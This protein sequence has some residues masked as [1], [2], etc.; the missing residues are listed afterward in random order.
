MRMRSDF[1]QS[2]NAKRKSGAG[3]SLGLDASVAYFCQDFIGWT[4]PIHWN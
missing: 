1:A 4:H 2:Y 3:A